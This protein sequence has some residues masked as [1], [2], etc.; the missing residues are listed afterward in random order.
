MSGT[1]LMNM[2]HAVIINSL[3]SRHVDLYFM[4]FHIG[5]VFLSIASKAATIRQDLS[6]DMESCTY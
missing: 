2:I 1:S 6:I 4:K 3:L 5:S